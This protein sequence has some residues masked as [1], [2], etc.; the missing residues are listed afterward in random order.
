MA[1]LTRNTGGVS[2]DM[3]SAAP[4]QLAKFDAKWKQKPNRTIEWG[5]ETNYLVVILSSRLN[6]T[7]F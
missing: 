7:Q 1:V 3:T 6:R 5:E 4:A 2:K